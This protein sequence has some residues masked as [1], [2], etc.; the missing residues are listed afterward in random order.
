MAA[1][2]E[3]VL[4]PLRETED[5]DAAAAAAEVLAP[6]TLPQNSIRVLT[7]VSGE[8]SAD[9]RALA[10]PPTR[11]ASPA[12]STGFSLPEAEAEAEADAERFLLPHLTLP[13]WD[14]PA[15]RD[16]PSSS[17]CCRRFA[18]R[19]ATKSLRESIARN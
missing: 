15:A 7:R 3:T 14:F 5:E 9:E 8:V 12:V 1:R 4:M 2:A 19:V 16:A 13:D 18:A 17:S 6:T 10:P 11:K